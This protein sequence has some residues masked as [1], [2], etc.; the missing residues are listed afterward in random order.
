MDLCSIKETMHMGILRGKTPGMVHKEIWAHLLAYNLIRK[1]M[2]Q[3]AVIHD[4]NPRQL[5]F[6]L[7][8][9]VIESFRQAGILSEDHDAYFELLR[10]IAHKQIGN[11]PG[12]QE[13]RKVKRRPKSFPRLQKP[14]SFYHKK[15]A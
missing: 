12:R 9:Q 15:A 10:A 3:A 1:I 7:A 11:R 5:S 2:A 6:K 8:L 14:R 13:P 4:K